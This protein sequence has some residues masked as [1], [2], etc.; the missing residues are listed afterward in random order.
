VVLLASA[1]RLKYNRLKKSGLKVPGV[2]IANREK[3]SA[4]NDMYRLGGNINYPTVKFVTQDGQEIS[5]APVLGF[6][7]QYEVIPPLSVTVFYDPIQPNSFC[8]DFA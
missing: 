4:N 8:I 1:D 7:T 3:R 2:I 5:G 6:V